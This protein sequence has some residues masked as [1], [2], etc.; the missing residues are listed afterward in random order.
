MM[1]AVHDE[2]EG[3]RVSGRYALTGIGDGRVWG[4]CAEVEGLFGE[5]RRGTYELFGWVP[6]ESGVPDRVGSRVWP[7]PDDA[8]LDAWLLEDVESLGKLPGTDSPVL[9]G[10]DDHMAPPEGYRGRVRLHDGR[11]RLGS[12]REFT[13][14]LGPEIV[15]SP[16][17][18]RRF[19]PSDQLRAA[20]A[21]GTRRALDLDEAALGIRDDG[22]ELLTER[23]LWATVRGWRPSARGAGLIDLEHAGGLVG[24]AVHQHPQVGADLVGGEPDAVRPAQGVRHPLRERPQQVRRPE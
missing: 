12:C 6:E 23:L 21:E 4:V 18:L 11:R 5:A 7:V 20:L 3:E 13:R 19:A 8:A 15:P 16:L 1:S 17:V 2:G 9:A 22:G 24:E 14:V 10:V